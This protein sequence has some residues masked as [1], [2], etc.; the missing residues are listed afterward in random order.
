MGWDMERIAKEYRHH[1]GIKARVLDERFMDMFDERALLWMARH[2][3]LI[4]ADEPMVDSPIA[5]L[6]ATS[7]RLRG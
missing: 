6:G 5:S 7:T 2:N 1:A 4:P 3:G